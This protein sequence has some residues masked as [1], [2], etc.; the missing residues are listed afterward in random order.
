MRQRITRRFSEVAAG[1]LAI[2]LSVS[3]ALAAPISWTTWRAAAS[4]PGLAADMPPNFG[5]DF[6]TAGVLR[7]FNAT[8]NWP[9]TGSFPTAKLDNPPPG[10]AG[11]D[12]IL[13]SNTCPHQTPCDFDGRPV[14][15]HATVTAPI[16]TDP[17][18]NAP[19]GFTVGAAVMAVPE[20]ATLLL[21][22]AGLSAFAIR[23]RDARRRRRREGDMDRG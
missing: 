17:V 12:S 16:A 1:G 3:P 20:P 22:G 18:F 6:A 4:R 15:F 19:P 9:L 11:V 21:F 5:V 23:R 7:G 8:P 14:A 10:A 13:L 2:A